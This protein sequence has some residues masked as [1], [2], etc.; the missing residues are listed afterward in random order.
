MQKHARAQHRVL[1]ND[2]LINLFH[3]GP[4]PSDSITVA[5]ETVEQRLARYRQELLT[6]VLREPRGLPRD[7][8]DLA[9]KIIA[10]QA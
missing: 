2:A 7:M 6:A 9:L 3:P 1:Q 8:R 4:G 5:A 10:L